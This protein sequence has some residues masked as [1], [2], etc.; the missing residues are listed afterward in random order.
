MRLGVI[1]TCTGRQLRVAANPLGRG[2]GGDVLTLT[3]TNRSDAVC[4]MTGFVG[5]RLIDGR[6]HRLRMTLRHVGTAAFVA[7][8]PGEAAW[9]SAT[10]TRCNAPGARLV[11]VALPG[12]S[13]AFTLRVGSGRR[14]YAPCHGRIN[15]SALN[16]A[17]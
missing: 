6:G 9:A 15:L 2:A 3:F 10:S 11:R 8:Y 14:P 7:L 1:P 5:L 16:P 17:F 13:A 4:R 12:T